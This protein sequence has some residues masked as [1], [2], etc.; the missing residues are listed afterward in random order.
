MLLARLFQD[1]GDRDYGKGIPQGKK[2]QVLLSG[3]SPWLDAGP[4]ICKGD[5]VDLRHHPGD[6]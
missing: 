6:R 3:G 2:E 1:T 5:P 4:H